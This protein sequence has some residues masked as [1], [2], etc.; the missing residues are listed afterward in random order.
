M[1]QARRPGTVSVADRASCGL[2]ICIHSDK[3][4]VRD[5]DLVASGGT[6]EDLLDGWVRQLGLEARC[7]ASIFTNSLPA[8]FAGR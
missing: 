4:S 3:T 1:E 7:C 5:L 2:K 6:G 8:S